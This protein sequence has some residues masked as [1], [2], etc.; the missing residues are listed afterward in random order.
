MN[1]ELRQ[2]T[3]ELDDSNAFLESILTSLGSGVAVLDRQMAVRV[4]NRHAEDL[5]GLRREEVHGH[6]FLNLDIGL[7][8][9]QLRQA[10]RA[11]AKGQSQQEY[12]VVQAVNRRGRTI[13]CAVTITP[14]LGADRAPDGVI[15]R[16]DQA[17]GMVDR[18]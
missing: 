9:D 17:D 7:P 5:W 1:G 12:I 6:H 16:M 10:I 3:H 11:T 13:D 15:I 8:V 4:W 2:R 14:L 18:R